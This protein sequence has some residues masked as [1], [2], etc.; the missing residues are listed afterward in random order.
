MNYSIL[1]SVYYKEK[2]EYFNEAIK[3]MLNQTV[4]SNDF[5][6]VCDGK[7][8]N[9]LYEILDKYESNPQNHIHRIQLEE[10]QGL[11][12]ALQKGLLECKNELIARMD[13]DDIALVTRM[14]LQLKE[15]DK[16]KNL[17]ICGGIVEE[18]NSNPGDLGILKKVPITQENIYKYAKKRNPFNHMTITFKKQYI[19]EV[20]NYQQIN[21]FEDY[22]L[23]M[24]MIKNNYQMININ[25][26]LVYMRVGNG[27]Y[28]R[29]GGITYAKDEINLQ[30][31]FYELKLIEKKTMLFNVCIRSI[32]RIMP[33]SIRKIVYKIIRK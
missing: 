5:V 28:A 16:N 17:V 6:I 31:R 21:L 30:K 20:G 3:S 14:E 4:K 32:I 2:P 26:V 23:W 10:N 22:F 9:E 13:S 7:L 15:F 33:V 29:R 18:F 19:I 1:M 24:R 11:G 25:N 27:M 12:I 8:T